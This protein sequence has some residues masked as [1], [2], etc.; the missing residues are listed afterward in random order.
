MLDRIAGQAAACVDGAD[1]KDLVRL[2]QAFQL[3][4]LK[5]EGLL[6]VLDVW[7]DKRLAA[8]NASGIGLAMAHFARV[9]EASPRLLKTAVEVAE[10]NVERL[11]ASDASRLLWAFAHLQYDPGQVLRRKGVQV[12]AGTGVCGDINVNG[13]SMSDRELANLFWGLV[14]LEE[15][16][17]V[18]ERASIAAALVRAPGKVSGQSAALLLWS[19]ASCQEA[20]LGH[21]SDTRAD[22]RTRRKAEGDNA[23]EFGGFDGFEKS[24]YRLGL[25][26]CADV[27]SV[28]SQSISMTGWS[29]GVLKIKHPEFAACLDT[30]GDTLQTFEPQHVA[31]LVWGLAKSG[32]RP[33]QEFMLDVADA[34]SGQMRLYSPQEVFNVCW[35]FATMGFASQTV[36]AETLAEL[37]ARGSEFGGLELSGISWALGRMLKRSS[38]P[39]IAEQSR[40]VIQ[41]HLSKRVGELEPSQVAMAVAGLGRLSARHGDDDDDDGDDD[42]DDE[43]LVSDLVDVFCASF[44]GKAF[45]SISSV[46]T[47]LEGLALRRQTPGSPARGALEAALRDED[48]LSRCLMRAQF[49]E[50][51]DL[52]Y[53]MSQNDMPLAKR[54]LLDIDA[55]IAAEPVTPR[56]AIMLLEAMRRCAV[57]PPVVLDK[58]TSK[59]SALSPNYRL[60]EEWLAILRGALREDEQLG[61]RV[62]FEHGQWN[63]RML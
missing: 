58:A 11:T 52:C 1:P 54:V 49:W 56:G 20:S 41:E 21:R 9:G 4:G 23:F 24:M 6:D 34:L 14:R 7:A 46:N 12:L 31:N 28:D 27:R 29:L 30:L 26:L 45:P 8:M 19:F 3:A 43:A 22:R 59:I 35:G 13:T 61:R 33:S 48:V 16:P 40:R 51:C 25:D 50:I 5:P 38:D 10:A 55:A 53:Y 60:G 2:I 47:L 63:E 32:S 37:K 57:Y 18:E 62:R 44:R 42:D 15:Y 39:S 17:S 36:A